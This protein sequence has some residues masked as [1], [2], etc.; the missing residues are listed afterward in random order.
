YRIETTD[1]N[2]RM[3]ISASG[4]TLPR[5]SGIKHLIVSIRDWKTAKVKAAHTNLCRRPLVR[6]SVRRV[7]SGSKPARR[8]KDHLGS[9]RALLINDLGPF[10]RLLD[11][12]RI[13]VRHYS[14]CRP[15]RFGC[16][17]LTSD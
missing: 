4:R 16:P 5:M 7:S 11:F 8:D 2:Y 9:N 3:S 17:G 12:E 13:F 15:R 6:R 10:S 14:L 1:I